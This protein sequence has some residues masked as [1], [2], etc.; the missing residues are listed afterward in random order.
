MTSDTTNLVLEDL[1][2]ESSLKFTLP[3][4]S[5]GDISGF[6]T[7][8]EDDEVFLRGERGSV[9]RGVGGIGLKNFEVV[10]IDDLGL[11]VIVLVR[12]IPLEVG[13]RGLGA[14]LSSLVLGSSHKICS[15]GRHL[16]VRDQSTILVRLDVLDEL[17]VLATA[18]PSAILS[19]V[20]IDHHLP[21]SL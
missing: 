21:C 19:P 14:N 3:L 15:V 18:N 12:L 5:G 17:S 6:L 2:V 10:Y 20:T 1:V 16:D 11:R 8:A 13:Y 7:T 4:R 9:E